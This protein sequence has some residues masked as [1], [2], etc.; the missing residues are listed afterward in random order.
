MIESIEIQVPRTYIVTTI[1]D[2]AR[3]S[4]IPFDGIVFSS[5]YMLVKKMNNR[6]FNPEAVDASELVR[7]RRV[8]LSKKTL[9]ALMSRCPKYMDPASAVIKSL[10]CMNWLR[11]KK[12][13]TQEL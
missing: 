13:Y 3:I 4:E 2:L 9:N 7:K 12:A 6:P 5:I 10:E 11:F 8:R 1:E